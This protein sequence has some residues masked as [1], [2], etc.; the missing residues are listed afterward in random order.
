MNNKEQGLYGKF[1]PVE[2]TDGQSKEGEKHFGCEYFILDLTHDPHA[3]PAI[4]EYINSCSAE[5]PQLAKDL[6]DRYLHDKEN[7]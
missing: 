1:C 6:T 7:D 3:I 2:R 5:F 4:Q